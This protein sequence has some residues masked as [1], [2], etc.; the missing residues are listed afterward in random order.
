MDPNGGLEGTIKAR[1][2]LNEERRWE[3]KQRQFREQQME[4]QR[5]EEAEQKKRKLAEEEAARRSVQAV[6]Q[7]QGEALLDPKAYFAQWQQFTGHGTGTRRQPG[8]ARPPFPRPQPAAQAGPPSTGPCGAGR[9]SRRTRAAAVAAPVTGMGLLSAYDSG[10]S[11]DGG[12]S[13]QPF[14]G[15]DPGSGKNLPGAR[16][17]PSNTAR[18]A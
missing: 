1:R 13:E 8:G 5:R 4:E 6:F 12:G 9:G 14:G 11:D 7:P 15:D 3:R 2:V 10:D 18:G 17:R 16:K